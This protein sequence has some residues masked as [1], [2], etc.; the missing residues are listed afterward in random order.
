M[1]QLTAPLGALLRHRLVQTA[2]GLGIGIALLWLAFARTDVAGL[3]RRLA[4]VEPAWLVLALLCYGTALAIRSWRWR[5]ILAPVRKLTFWQVYHSLIVGY[6]ANNVLPARLGELLRA[7]YLGRRYGISRLSV[8]G[9]I[10]VERL[11]DVVVFVGFILAGLATLHGRPDARVLPILHA[12]EIV[13]AGCVLLAFGLFIVLRL[14]HKA[15]PAA[16]SFLEERIRSLADGLHL[17]TGIQEVAILAAATAV[18][19]TADSTSTWLLCRALGVNPGLDELL[20]IMG[21]S[22]LAALIPAA[23]ANIGAL[24]YALVLAFQLL[25]YDADAGFGLA[26]L[27][28][29][30]FVG[31]STLAGGALY[32]IS[33]LSGAAARAQGKPGASTG[34]S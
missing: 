21:M 4:Q 29:G 30:C 3:G 11:F 16:F 27:I 15:L 7:D 31:S 10:V 32:L 5:I 14:K 25:G 20:L 24:Q 9:T 8:I 34:S 28:Q 26:L 12:A 2:L 6:A 23:P 33:T 13:G 17:V 1:G 18:V 22:C 19:W